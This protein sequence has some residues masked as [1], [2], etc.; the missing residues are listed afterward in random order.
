[1]LP[2]TLSIVVFAVDDFRLGRV[3]LQ[4]AFRESLLQDVE[5]PACLPLRLAVRNDVIGVAGKR[6]I[7]I[8]PLHPS[9]EY[10]MQEQIGQQRANHSALRRTPITLFQRTVWILDG[11]LEPTLNIEQH[12]RALRV[13]SNRSHQEIMI[14]P[15]KEALHVEIENPVIAPTP[16]ARDPYGINSRSTRPK[17][18]GVFVK[19]RL[20][21]RLQMSSS[22]PSGRS[23]PTTVGM[24]SWRTPADF[25]GISTLRTGAGK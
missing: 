11:R 13:M 10:V 4:T 7:R 6:N 23:D 19:M 25:F 8:A 21:Q 3:Q 16:L 15:I 1:M 22:R 18:I 12:P 2:G 14:D 5:Q 20:Q 17:S 24:P 9:I